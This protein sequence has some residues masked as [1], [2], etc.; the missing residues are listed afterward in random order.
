VTN[1]SNI[2]QSNKAAICIKEMASLVGLSRQRFMQLVKSGVFPAPLKDEVTGRPYF[3][4]EMQTVCLDVRRRNC[5]V[6]GQVIMFYARRTTSPTL[7]PRPKNVKPPKSP[8]PKSST[9]DHHADIVAGLHGLG[10]TV[11]GDQVAQA[12]TELF[13]KG[14][15]SSDTGSV[16]RAVFLHIRGKNSAEKVGRKE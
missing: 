11:T 13:P 1:S 12:V 4:D 6:N 3:T 14:I 9:T 7:P 2:P 16:I 15:G 8:K 5:G 10:L